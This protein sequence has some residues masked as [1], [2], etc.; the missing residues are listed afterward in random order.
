MIIPLQ[1][2][3]FSSG[4]SD[5]NTS[6]MESAVDGQ[7]KCDSQDTKNKRNLK[8]VMFVDA[9]K[10]NLVSSQEMFRKYGLHLSKVHFRG[11]VE[12]A[13]NLI[14]GSRIHYDNVFKL[15]FVDLDLLID[16]ANRKK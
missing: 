1:N 14:K 8:L 4:E 9:C 2:M 5:F 6:R 7:I 16:F 12:V 3:N 15:I 11:D 13:L 10:L